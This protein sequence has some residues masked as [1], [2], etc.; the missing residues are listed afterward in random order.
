MFRWI[1]ACV[2]IVAVACSSSS[3]E[4]AAVEAVGTSGGTVAVSEGSLAGASVEVPS[5]ALSE[6]ASISIAAGSSVDAG[7]DTMGVGPAGRTGRDQLTDVKAFIARVAPTGSDVVVV[8]CDRGA[9]GVP[10][11]A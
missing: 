4:P 3:S 5:G 11:L 10:D 8:G 1:F 2:W 6:T 9:D 7:S